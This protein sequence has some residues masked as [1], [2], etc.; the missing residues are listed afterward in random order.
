MLYYLKIYYII[1]KLI[2]NII[3]YPIILYDILLIYLVLYY[4]RSNYFRSISVNY[5]WHI[6]DTI[7]NVLKSN[8]RYIIHNILHI[9]IYI[10]I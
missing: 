9:L 6:F 8:K 2:S 5:I 7:N 4:T 10:Y 3:L 1:L